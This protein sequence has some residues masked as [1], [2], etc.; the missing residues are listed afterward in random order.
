MNKRKI[1]DNAAEEK[2][3]DNDDNTGKEEED[4]IT[5]TATVTAT[6]IQQL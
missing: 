3:D 2:G 4:D 5:M 1:K 6:I